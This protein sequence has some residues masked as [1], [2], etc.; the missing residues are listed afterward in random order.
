VDAAAGKRLEEAE[1]REG[2]E[3]VGTAPGVK[4][5]AAMLGVEE[6]VPGVEEAVATLGVRARRRGGSGGHR[7]E[8]VEVTGESGG[9][10]GEWRPPLGR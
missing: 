1:V 10:G 5:V 8:G 3:K 4:E 7:R 9:R 6:V 2:V